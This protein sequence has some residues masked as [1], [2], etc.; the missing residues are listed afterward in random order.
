MEEMDMLMMTID[1]TV[2]SAAISSRWRTRRVGY[3]SFSQH[4]ACAGGD[5]T[6]PALL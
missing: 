3:S 1:T 2:L 5:L 4:D 6:A